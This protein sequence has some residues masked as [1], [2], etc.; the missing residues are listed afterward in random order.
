L[1]GLLR[2]LANG[3]DLVFAE[4]TEGDHL[5]RNTRERVALAPGRLLFPGAV[6]ERAARVGTVLVEEA[7]HLGLD[8]RGALTGAHHLFCLLGGE[9]YGERVHAVYAPGVDAEAETA[10]RQAVLAGDLLHTGGHRVEVVLNEEAERELP[11]GGEVHR[12][13]H[14]ADVDRAV[15]EVA[16]GDV[17]GSRT[18][19]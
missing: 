3:R 1:H 18:L 10:R 6:A 17:G 9:V 16:H 19:L 5:L 11:C 4:V 7:V 2:L 14:G 15:A 13:E 8:D 12:L